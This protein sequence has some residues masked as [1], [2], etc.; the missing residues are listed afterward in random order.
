LLF[1][2]AFIFDYKHHAFA[3]S[4]HDKLFQA[5]ASKQQFSALTVY[6]FA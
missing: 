3:L 5:A 2:I 4:Y 6:Y 1:T